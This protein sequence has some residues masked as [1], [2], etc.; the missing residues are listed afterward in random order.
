[1]LQISNQSFAALSED[2]LSG[3]I[4]KC[5]IFL[6]QHNLTDGRSPQQLEARIRMRLPEYA[7]ASLESE[8]AA[9]LLISLEM[10]ANR[11]VLADPQIANGLA[12]LPADESV[13]I[14]W[15]IAHLARRSDWASALAQP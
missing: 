7:D 12:R 5:L 10:K 15:L 6:T 3:F 8:R 4:Q 11:P 14:D 1:M 2:K 9:V 13:R